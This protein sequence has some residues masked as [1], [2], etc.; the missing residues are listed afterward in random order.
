MAIAP[1]RGFLVAFEGA[2]GLGKSTQ[3]RM[4]TTRLEKGNTL[5]K[6]FDFPHKDGTPIGNLI[7]AF[8]RG[9]FGEVTPEFLGL[10][11]AL[12][13][14][15]SRA[16]LTESLAAGLLVIC[17][18]Y[19]SSNVAF[20]RAKITD[21]TRRAELDLLIGWVEYSLLALPRPSLE[22]MLVAD[23][24]YFLDRQHWQR[25]GDQSRDY[26]QDSNDIHEASTELQI[27]VNRFFRALPPKS[28]IKKIS[29][30]DSAMRRRSPEDMHEEI[31]STLIRM[32]DG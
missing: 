3:V 17:D 13:R 24:T 10:S 27:E 26:I 32:L 9:K 16:E 31:W 30:Q 8:L 23:E 19:V 14:Y 2:D 21:T 25:Q 4:L 12:D 5:I 7:G 29:V 15:S 11:F 6:Q 28:N 22:I 18:R 20:Q 1:R